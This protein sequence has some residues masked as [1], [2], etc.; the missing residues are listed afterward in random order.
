MRIKIGLRKL[1]PNI[2]WNQPP[3]VIGFLLNTTQINM[4][5]YKNL[6]HP[7][8]HQWRKLNNMM[9][10]YEHLMMFGNLEYFKEI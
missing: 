2:L 10:M 3:L 7:L 1:D 6:N 4:E 5:S 9:R 8:N